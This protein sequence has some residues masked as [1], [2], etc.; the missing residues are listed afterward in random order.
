LQGILKGFG[1]TS[2]TVSDSDILQG[3]ILD[4]SRR[5]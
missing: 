2:F 5:R 1:A 4:A 3:I